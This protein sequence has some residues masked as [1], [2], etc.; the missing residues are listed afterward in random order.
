MLGNLWH[1][2][3]ANSTQKSRRGF[4]MVY[5]QPWLRTLE[6]HFLSIPFKIA[7]RLD[8]RIQSVIGT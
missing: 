4:I 6:N 1:G 5:T 8:P 7:A 3:G 2:G